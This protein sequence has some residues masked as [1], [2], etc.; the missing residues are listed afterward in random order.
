MAKENPTGELITYSPA[1]I[2]EQARREKV[3]EQRNKKLKDPNDAAKPADQPTT[4]PLAATD[5]ALPA[6]PAS[7]AT[8]ATKTGGTRKR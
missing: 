7:K 8:T 3:A 4:E 5:S 1:Q 6:G 2:A